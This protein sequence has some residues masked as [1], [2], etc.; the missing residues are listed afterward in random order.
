MVSERPLDGRQDAGF[1]CDCARL[2]WG[3]RLPLLFPPGHQLF[4]ITSL[5]LQRTEAKFYTVQLS[6]HRKTAF[7]LFTRLQKGDPLC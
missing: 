2:L 3:E 5:I 1:G 7:F 4:P 6:V